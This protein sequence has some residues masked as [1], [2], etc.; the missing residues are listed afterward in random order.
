LHST[1]PGTEQTNREAS[2]LTIPHS[3]GTSQP[4]ARRIPSGVAPSTGQHPQVQLRQSTT[5]G[6]AHTRATHR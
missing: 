3:Q 1:R 4:N 2:P 6:S 5:K